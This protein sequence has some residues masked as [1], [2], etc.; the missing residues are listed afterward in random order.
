M[1]AKQ[2]VLKSL[3]AALHNVLADERV[4]FMGEDILDPYGGAFKI[5]RGLSTCLLYT[6]PSPR[7]RG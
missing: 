5:S 2:N 7:D 3:N 4:V 1:S 6:S